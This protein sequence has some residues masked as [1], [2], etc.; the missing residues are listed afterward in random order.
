MFFLKPRRNPEIDVYAF[1]DQLHATLGARLESVIVFGSLARGEYHSKRS[2]VNVLIIADMSVD[3]L[4]R[5]G[6]P[7]KKWLKRGYIA[8]VLVEK[9]G[10]DEFAQDFPIEFLDMKD[11]HRVIYGENPFSTLDVKT[12]HLKGQCEHDLALVQLRLRQAIAAAQGSRKS[13]LEMLIRSLP[14]VK[15]LFQATM[16]LEESGVNLDKIRAIDQLG[17]RLGFDPSIIRK[18]EAVQLQRESDNVNGLA[19]Q[20]LKMISLVLNHLRK[21]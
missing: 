8:P 4:N 2:N 12:H 7:I 3:T 14:S 11:E 1:K 18:I 15:S 10:L 9:E 20:Y 5:M 16:R 6:G 19:E 21:A 17:A 13:L